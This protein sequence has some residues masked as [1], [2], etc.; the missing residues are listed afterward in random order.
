MTV[1]S[2]LF[3]FL[4]SRLA[5]HAAYV[6]DV[7]V[8]ALCVLHA[9]F[10]Q[11]FFQFAAQAL[12][13]DQQFVQLAVAERVLAAVLQPAVDAPYGGFELARK[14]LVTRRTAQKPRVRIL[15]ERRAADGTARALLLFGRKEGDEEVRLRDVFGRRRPAGVAFLAEEGLALLALYRVRRGIFFAVG[16]KTFSLHPLLS[17]SPAEYF[18]GCARAACP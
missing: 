3:T 15:F 17:P 6:A 5:D 12:L 14:G 16:A 8:D 4:P 9:L 10:A 7:A 11:G 13:F 18:S 1:L 2:M